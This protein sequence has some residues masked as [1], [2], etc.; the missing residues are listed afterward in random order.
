MPISTSS[1]L[2]TPRL[3]VGSTAAARN[4]NMSPTRWSVGIGHSTL[5]SGL[6][7]GPTTDSVV[8]SMTLPFSRNSTRATRALSDAP[9]DSVMEVPS[10]TTSW[11]GGSTR[12]TS[13]GTVSLTVPN[14]TG[15]DCVSWSAESTATAVRTSVRL[16]LP[17][18]GW[19]VAAKRVGLPEIPA[20]AVEV[21]TFRPSTKKWTAFTAPSMSRASASRRTEALSK[22]A[23]PA[24]GEVTVTVGG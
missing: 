10:V 20:G 13:G 19:N 16:P 8:E 15:S 6:F 14:S 23:L 12:S 1:L 22:I 11:P 3:P 9:A 4:S 7:A 2:D 17:N 21:A 5:Y 24:G 18:S